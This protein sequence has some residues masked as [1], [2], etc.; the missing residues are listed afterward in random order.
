[1][2]R[3][4]FHPAAMD[5]EA[6][7]VAGR[8]Q[9]IALDAWELRRAIA[10]NRCDLRGQ[11]AVLHWLL[12]S[13]LPEVVLQVLPEMPE[14]LTELAHADEPADGMFASATGDE[15]WGEP[16]DGGRLRGL[17]LSPSLPP[18]HCAWRHPLPDPVLTNLR[19]SLAVF[20]GQVQEGRHLTVAPGGVPLDV[21]D[22]GSA[23]HASPQAGR[24]PMPPPSVSRESS[25]TKPHPPPPEMI[26]WSLAEGGGAVE[27][28]ASPR[29]AC[30]RPLDQ[31]AAAALSADSRHAHRTAARVPASVAGQLDGTVR[32]HTA[33]PPPLQVSLRGQACQL[34][35]TY[36][37]DARAAHGKL[38]AVREL[39]RRQA[40]G[41][42]GACQLVHVKAAWCE[43]ADT[44]APG[45]SG[46]LAAHV[47]CVQLAAPEAPQS[48]RSKLGS[49]APPRWEMFEVVGGLCAAL[50]TLHSVGL[51]CEA[52]VD[53]DAVIVGPMPAVHGRSSEHGADD[54][55]AWGR[56]RAVAGA[57]SQPAEQQGR[58]SEL[59]V[60]LSW[61]GR[62][63]P[64]GAAGT[65]DATGRDAPSS[66]SHIDAKWAAAAVDPALRTP[67]ASAAEASAAAG[68]SCGVDG[69]GGGG[70]AFAADVWA[71]G[72]LLW[73]LLLCAPTDPPPTTHTPGMTHL[74][75]RTA[76]E[77]SDSREEL[78]HQL[79]RSM[80][81]VAPHERPSAAQLLFS[82]KEFSF[83]EGAIDDGSL[84]ATLRALHK[85][86]LDRTVDA[87]RPQLSNPQA[88]QLRSPPLP[89][90]PL[91]SSRDRPLAQP[92]AA[93]RPAAHQPPSQRPAALPPRC[94]LHASALPADMLGFVRRLTADEL[95]MCPLV[96][97]IDDAHVEIA[98]HDDVCMADAAGSTAGLPSDSL[99]VDS[100]PPVQIS[101]EMAIRLF[102]RGCLE[103][104]LSPPPFQVAPTLPLIPNTEPG[105]PADAP[106]PQSDESLGEGST[107]MHE[108]I[109]R[110]LAYSLAQGVPWPS[111]LPTCLLKAMLARSAHLD[112][113]DLE[114]ARPRL[115][116][117]CAL[118]LSSVIGP[119]FDDVDCERPMD[120]RMCLPEEDETKLEALNRVLRWRLYESRSIATE[121]LARGF[122]AALES[123]GFDAGARPL[124][125]PLSAQSLALAGCAGRPLSADE[126]LGS[127]RFVGFH[128]RADAYDKPSVEEEL[129]RAWVHRATP[130]HRCARGMQHTHTCIRTH[131][132]MQ[133]DAAPPVCTTPTAA[134]PRMR[135]Q[136]CTHALPPPAGPAAPSEPCAPPPLESCG[137]GASL[138]SASPAAPRPPRLRAPAHPTARRR[139]RPGTFTSRPLCSRWAIKGQ[140][141]AG[142]AS[143]SKRCCAQDRAQACA[144]S[145]RRGRCCCLPTSTRRDLSE[146]WP[147]CFARP[148]CRPPYDPPRPRP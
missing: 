108:D 90:P 68:G 53:L 112:F 86:I 52:A 141:L 93:E 99:P 7:T 111:W 73:R 124:L 147:T 125:S 83:K 63:T 71:L 84:A 48:W 118:V 148:S 88:G 131:A 42:A 61:L 74:E 26:A 39:Q 126:L 29:I 15:E 38:A 138:S 78:A 28:V 72:I 117:R 142:P 135:S 103:H 137:P 4:A 33:H 55:P 69:G 146:R 21:V 113:G 18:L 130:L 37:R 22:A 19:L 2:R 66:P 129:F 76:R 106:L 23:A 51:H 59:A 120:M 70:D 115:A 25:A 89:S 102:W 104:G 105:L 46:E 87:A 60:H 79:L 45:C 77:P 110:M 11:E 36:V 127:I 114:G 24:L 3:D 97:L 96:L 107:A 32:S 94:V 80:L 54:E 31:E 40:A 132:R 5:W 144:C 20:T 100:P 121:A 136:A 65:S 8:D 13:G 64:G 17:S 85:A 119:E 92:H 116:C 43:L 14:L 143:E 58:S 27:P 57:R 98:A 1:M 95:L 10:R 12:C 145:V 44:L 101:L 134:A 139:G 82:F 49:S 50:A 140:C 122:R 30:F 9:A 75:P 62:L 67:G 41:C 109:G 35:L 16:L 91:P 123:A 133:G 128:R 34:S 81:R 47:V 6:G 56:L